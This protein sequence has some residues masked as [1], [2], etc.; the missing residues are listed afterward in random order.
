[1]FAVIEAVMPPEAFLVVDGK[2][3][4]EAAE[5]FLVREQPFLYLDP[6]WNGC[7]GTGIPFAMAA[8]L[9][10]PGRPLL[11]VTGDLAFGMGAIELE[12]AVR[13][14]LPFVVLVVNNDGAEGLQNQITKLP[15]DHP[16]RVH[17][18]QSALAYDQVAGGLGFPACQASTPEELHQALSRGLGSGKPLLINTLVDPLSMAADRA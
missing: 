10:H 2:I 11:L 3:T 15:P 7:M 8:R 14:Q 17:A 6:G 13:H 18:F 5:R 9:H 1:M 4:L 16:E 12:T